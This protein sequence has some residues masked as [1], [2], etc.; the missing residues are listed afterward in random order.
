MNKY[1]DFYSDF[2]VMFNTKK[3]FTNLSDRSNF[4]NNLENIIKKAV[5][6]TK[7]IILCLNSNSKPGS[8]EVSKIFEKYGFV[9]IIEK[10]HNYQV[11]GKIKKNTNLEQLIILKVGELDEKNKKSDKGSTV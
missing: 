2:D 9:S 6:K 5:T 11:S 4:M 3:Q 10:K 1:E 8:K 7:Y